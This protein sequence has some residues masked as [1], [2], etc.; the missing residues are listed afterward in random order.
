V[1]DVSKDAGM[2][3]VLVKRMERNRL[4]M[5]LSIK[6]SVDKGDKLT[7]FEIEFLEE[8]LHDAQCLLPLV[9]RHPEYQSL[10]MKVYDLYKDITDKALAN[11]S[12]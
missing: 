2:L 10:A 9:E 11:E 8:A 1:V 12:H 7:E 3:Q 5:A 6:K 4:P